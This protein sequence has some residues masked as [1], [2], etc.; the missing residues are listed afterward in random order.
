MPDNSLTIPTEEAGASGF[1]Q[2]SVLY[3][4]LETSPGQVFTLPHLQSARAEGRKSRR[5]VVKAAR[6][7]E[8]FSEHIR[9]G[10]DK[11]AD[12][13]VG[14]RL[15]A[16][17][18]PD[19]G[20]L[21]IEDQAARENL[22]SDLDRNFRTWAYDNRLLQDAEG[23]YDFGG[24]MWMALRNLQ[25][26]DGECAGIIHFDEKRRRRYNARY[27]TYLQIFDPDRIET[28]AEQVGN[29]NVQ[30]GKIL[31]ENG[32]MLGMF[33][34]K[35]HQSDVVMSSPEYEIVD[36]E[37][38]TGRPIGFHWFVKTRA[39]QLRGISTLVTIIKQTGMVDQ[40][41]DAYLAAA[42][43]NQ[44]LA[45][46]IESAAPVEVVKENLAPAVD[47]KAAWSMFEN[48]LDYYQKTKLRFGGARLPV[49]PPG[50]KINMSAVNRAIDDPSAFRNSFLRE[51]ASAIGIS[52]EQIAMTFGDSNFSAA[53]AA[54][55][56]AW[57]GILKLRYQFGQHV[58]ALV[59]DAVTEEG[60]DKGYV[61]LPAGAPDF[62]EQRS[63][64]TIVEWTGPGMPQID[65][66]KEAKANRIMLED[67]LISREEVISQRGGNYILVFDQIGKEREEAQERGFALDPLK[68]G[69]PG[70]DPAGAAPEDTGGQGGKSK[71]KTKKNGS[72]KDG[73]GDGLLQEGE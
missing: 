57:Q 20:A 28:P 50:D 40:F 67:K 22:A 25:G 54:I 4:N 70:A 17:P 37:S 66:E 16:H 60:I 3:R 14:P 45:T 56:D 10:L 29:D 18:R 15:M 21:G 42:L 49:M 24:L 26:P 31:D 73:D 1:S 2:A 32:R 9:G 35:V 41:D 27:A 72:V 46:W 11:K 19:F 7:I 13:T 38:N 53:R 44:M 48:K 43:I 65:P 61:K 63:A 55:L 64:Y 51:F 23:H 6:H 62:Y 68:P 59:Y 52:F 12:Y 39:S 47:D 33:V 69:T 34:R 71:N 30:D 8:R 36:R 58:A 5:D